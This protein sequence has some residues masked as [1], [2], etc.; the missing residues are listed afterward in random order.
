MADCR[1]APATVAAAEVALEAV[2]VAVVAAVRVARELALVQQV[3]G[4]RVPAAVEWVV[5]HSYRMV[6]LAHRGP[7][8]RCAICDPQCVSAAA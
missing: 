1:A 4:E 8:R 6:R 7:R 2:A 5:G 3:A